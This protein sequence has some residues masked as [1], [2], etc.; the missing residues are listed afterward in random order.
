MLSPP[1]I[2]PVDCILVPKT[3]RFYGIHHSS[4]LPLA[5][6]LFKCFLPCLRQRVKHMKLGW[7]GIGRGP[8]CVHT[9]QL[10]VHVFLNHE[11]IKPTRDKEHG[12][13]RTLVARDVASTGLVWGC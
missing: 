7:A 3:C 11:S 5:R 2:A 10:S 8:C 4:Q 9:A 12:H 1:S 13:R 6:R